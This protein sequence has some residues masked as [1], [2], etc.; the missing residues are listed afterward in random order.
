MKNQRQLALD[1]QKL[2]HDDALF[3]LPNAWD[4]G[5]AYIFEKAGYKSVATTSAGIAYSLGYAD[6]E[7][8]TFDDLLRVIHQITRRI[9]VPLSVDIERG[10]ATTAHDVAAN[11]RSVIEAGAVGINI[12][13]GY[14]G[15]E[16]YLESVSEQVQ[17]ISHIAA[18]KKELDIPFVIN[19]RT[20]T[21]LLQIGDEATRISSV[22]ERCN[23]YASA[24]ADCIF[25]PG[26]LDQKTVATLVQQIDAPINI[27][28]TPSFD[29]IEA[30]QTIGVRRLSLGSGPVRTA[31]ATLIS[32]ASS[33][34]NN[35]NLDSL[36]G[37]SFSY[38]EANHFFNTP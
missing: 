30:M 7:V 13:D 37:H 17:K 36:F 8:I 18:L 25:I 14:P 26:A 11:V 9:S 34:Q 29:D 23:A 19:A 38:A 16:P 15:N 31:Y 12:E 10:Y 28:A 3:I 20:C 27:L 24:G 4:A 35:H 6:G 33:I 21:C 22:I 2:H 32:L 1:F 5:S